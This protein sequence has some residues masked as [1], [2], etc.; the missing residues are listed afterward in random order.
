[1]AIENNFHREGNNKYVSRENTS[2]FKTI[3]HMIYG[4]LENTLR[5]NFHTFYLNDLSFNSTFIRARFKLFVT[6]IR[7]HLFMLWS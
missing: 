4:V 1:M 3:F 5:L 7:N 6:W 2:T